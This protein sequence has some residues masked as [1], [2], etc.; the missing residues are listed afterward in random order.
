MVSG[1]NRSEIEIDVFDGQSRSASGLSPSIN[2]DRKGE[3]RGG[4][5]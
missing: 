1:K 5:F 3:R 2:I 4:G